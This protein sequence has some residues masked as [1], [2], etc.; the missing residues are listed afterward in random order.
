MVLQIGVVVNRGQTPARKPCTQVSFSQQCFPAPK[1]SDLIFANQLVH[2][3]R[4]YS[5]ASIVVKYSLGSIG[6]L[7]LLRCR[8]C[9]FWCHFNTGGLILS[10]VDK[11]LDWNESL[12]WSPVQWKSQR[13]PRVVTSTL[14]AE[15]QV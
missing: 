13:L 9:E 7:L 12:P 2:R 14:G 11:C 15:A 6:S 1:V 10:F 5:D 3:A 4:Q 8:V